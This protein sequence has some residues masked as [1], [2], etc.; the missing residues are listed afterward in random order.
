[1][2]IFAD[3]KNWPLAAKVYFGLAVFSTVVLI[4][5][6]LLVLLGLGEQGM[7]DVA[8]DVGVDID[9]DHALSGISGITFFSFRSLV[10]FFCFFGWVGFIC[11]RSGVWSLLALVFASLAGLVAFFCVAFLLRFFYSMAVSGTVN[12]KEAIGEIGTVY[13]VIPEGKNMTGVV[14]VMVGGA[15]REY[16]AISENGKEIKTN[17]RVQIT[18]LLDAS[19]LI[20]KPA[21]SPSDWMENGL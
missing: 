3:F 1:M 16:K 18:G 21:Q 12:I 9:V 17:E 10:A 2:E 19:T 11:I 4:L 7:D 13:L 20:V 5:Q 15:L 8:H 14:N 6:M